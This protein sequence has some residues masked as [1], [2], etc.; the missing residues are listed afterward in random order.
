MQRTEKEEIISELHDNFSAAQSAI[1]VGYHGLTVRSITDIRRAFRA[2]GVS[3][4]VLKNTFA[5]R[6]AQGTPLEALSQDFKGPVAIAYSNTDP[7]APAKIAQDCAKKDGKFQI[8]CGYVDNT[9]LDEKGVS[10]LATLPGKNELRAKFLNLLITPATQLV[11]T[12]NAA[13]QQMALV[14]SAREAS[15]KESSETNS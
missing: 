5:K 3:F 8:K 9:R 6:A 13:P 1:L 2:E 11:R 4:R 15:L 14:L 12:M 10:Q 7:V